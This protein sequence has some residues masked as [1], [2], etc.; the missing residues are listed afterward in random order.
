MGCFPF[1]RKIILIAC[2]CCM[3]SGMAEFSKAIAA[4]VNSSIPSNKSECT[5][6]LLKNRD[7]LPALITTIDEAQNEIL[8]AFFLFKAGVKSESY[9][10]KVLAHLLSA[11]KRGVKVIVILGN[12]GGRDHKLDSENQQ[13]VELLKAKG[14]EA[15]CDT[16]K[17]TTHTK[18]IVIDQRLVI[19][20]SHNLTQAAMKYNNEISILL[21]NPELAQRARDYML[22]IMKEAK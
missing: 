21:D 20:G 16:P 3:F 13:T 8:M 10:D 9:P 6:V 11:V 2:S 4:E 15:F 7:Y 22:T 17:R 5:A 12:T 19:L 14:M 18:L 1:V